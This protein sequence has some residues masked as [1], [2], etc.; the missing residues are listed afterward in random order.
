MEKTCTNCE[1]WESE[2]G[3]A[4]PLGLVAIGIENQTRAKNVEAGCT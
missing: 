4:C 1:F 3:S 2:E